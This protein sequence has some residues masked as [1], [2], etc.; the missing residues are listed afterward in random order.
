M[1]QFNWTF[2][3]NPL[4]TE[5]D[6]ATEAFMALCKGVT[7]LHPEDDLATK[8]ANLD[9]DWPDLLSFLAS[10]YRLQARSSY[11]GA[12]VQCVH[13]IWRREPKFRELLEQHARHS[14][15]QL[16]EVC[17]ILPWLNDDEWKAVYGAEAAADASA[18]S[19]MEAASVARVQQFAPPRAA[20]G[21]FFG[22]A[23]K[24]FRCGEV[25]GYVCR[26][27]GFGWR[28]RTHDARCSTR[29]LERS[30]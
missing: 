3:T 22:R 1:K 30:H 27:K 5:F 4:T 26:R 6:K 9:A 25:Q 23:Q 13:N 18:S 12:I 14:P 21:T 2:P 11:R 10:M 7:G 24:C 8:I 29:M 15:Y 20:N 16:S 28:Q 19:Q 17:V